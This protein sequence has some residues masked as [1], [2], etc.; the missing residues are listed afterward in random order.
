MDN[1]GYDPTLGI[2]VWAVDRG[3]MKRGSRAGSFL[4]GHFSIRID[5]KYF[6][7]RALAFKKLLGWAPDAKNITYVDGDA[8]N[9]RASNLHYRGYT[10]ADLTHSPTYHT[11]LDESRGPAF[12]VS[13]METRGDSTR[14]VTR[15]EDEHTAYIRA[16]ERQKRLSNLP[17]PITVEIEIDYL[18]GYLHVNQTVD[19]DT[20]SQPSETMR[21]A[22]NMAAAILDDCAR[23][24][25]Q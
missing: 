13:L 20:V 4:N 2:F 19:G 12:R 23:E 9:L 25:G 16:E 7:C 21:E 3:P 14:L 6:P 22:V 5:G 8:R 17:K 1:L 24:L 11:T 15:C 18:T 10:L